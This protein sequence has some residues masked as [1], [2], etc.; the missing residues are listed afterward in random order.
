MT[1]RN[2]SGGPKNTGGVIILE[3]VQRRLAAAAAGKSRPSPLATGRGTFRA[4]Q[5]QRRTPEELLIDTLCIDTIRT[6]SIDAVQQANSGHP[7]TPMAMAPVAY[8]LWQDFLR[9][10][11]E[12][13]GWLNRDRFVLSAGH[14]SMLLY[15]LLHLSAVKETEGGEVLSV[16]LDDIRRFRQ[17]GS[18]CTGHPEHPLTAGVETTTGPLGQGCATSVGMAMASRWMAAHFNR[19]SFTMVD[20]DVYALCSDGDMMEGVASETA[21]LAG[22]LRLG[23]L[24]WIY[25]NNQITIEGHTDLA[26]SEDVAARFQAYGWKVHHIVDANDTDRLTQALQA[27]RETADRPT[28]IIVD[29]HIGYGSPNKHDSSAA[30]GEPLGADEVRLTKRFYGWPEEARFLIPEGVREHFKAGIG[31]RGRLLREAWMQRREAYRG[32]YPELADQLDRLHK[33]ELPED[34][35]VDLPSFPADAKGMPTRAAS[36]KVLNAIAPRYPWLMG[37]AGDLGSSTMSHLGF[38]GA[39]DFE[40]ATYGGRNLHFGIREHAMAAVVNGLALSGMR[41]YGST[42]LVFSDY[43]KPALRLSALM[44]L[45]TIHLFSHDSIGVGEDGPTHQPVEHLIALR[46]IPG[47]ITLRPADANEVVEAWRLMMTLRYR[48]VSLILSRQPVPTLDRGRYAPAAGL[49]LGGYV[50]AD[51]ADGKPEVILIGTGS[52]VALCVEAYETL[53]RDGVAAR[54]VSLPSWEL[55]EEQSQA[56]RDQ[57]LPP[58]VTARVSVEAG[59]V[60]G[61]DRYAGVTGTKIGMRTFGSSAPFK[62]LRETFGFTPEQV[63][64]AARQHLTSVNTSPR[65]E[66]RPDEQTGIS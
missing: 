23:N 32:T 17:L 38:E 63:V 22:H 59:S 44:E 1:D 15:T 14:A 19:P 66:A 30:H 2:Y 57:V 9:Y 25:D 55:F 61:W 45:P 29:S 6:L 10:D 49:A 42:Y 35:D 56:Y 43:L 7:G 24:C 28:L 5:P 12:D 50:L 64:E 33:G 58:H 60:L 3:S 36:G 39:G 16:T 20:Y 46:A 62:D 40:A 48:P 51:A 54:V 11:P 26:F 53:T 31:T 41:A 65:Q 13:A 18:P 8:T 34:W 4:R 37:G 21:S 52:E 47:M 27:F